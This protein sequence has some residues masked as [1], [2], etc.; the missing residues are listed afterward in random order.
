MKRTGLVLIIIAVIGVYVFPML[1]VGIGEVIV[2]FGYWPYNYLNAVLL[3]S[4]TLPISLILG[5][6]GLVM[7]WVSRKKGQVVN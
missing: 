1:A 5:V 3:P 2:G 6:I 4:F 7:L